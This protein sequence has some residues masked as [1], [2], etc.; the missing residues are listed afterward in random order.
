[1]ISLEG[2]VSSCDHIQEGLEKMSKEMGRSRLEK[3]HTVES[4]GKN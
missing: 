2:L 3:I 4:L 1:M